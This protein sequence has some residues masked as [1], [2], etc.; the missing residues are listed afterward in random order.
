[1]YV[2]DV[3]A[4]LRRR[5]YIVVT[6]LLLTGG[7]CALAFEYVP[8]SFIARGSMILLPP[9]TV[10]DGENPYL[11]LGGLAP[12]LDVLTRR[13]DADKIR[14]PIEDAFPE[15]EFTVFAD[16]SSSGPIIAIEITAPTAREAFAVTDAVRAVIPV[17]LE[18]MQTELD[19]PTGSRIALSP[20]SV[21]E[22]ATR[23]T[24]TRTQALAV[25][26]GLGLGATVLLTGLVDGLLL[27]RRS[28]RNEIAGA[29]V[30][31]PGP[32]DAEREAA[33][34][35]ELGVDASADQAP[36]LAADRPTEPV[37]RSDQLRMTDPR[38]S[39]RRVRK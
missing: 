21:D 34:L 16:R 27:A 13:V 30:S 7:L 31:S 10:T 11:Y 20:V 24:S 18:Q 1:M 28:R 12:A 32:L 14:L 26:G 29:P 4:G 25:L 35:G 15:A 19:V 2:R 39:L 36:S 22:E 3:V 17:A 8:I 33:D 6:G 9:E 38:G 23:D 5:W 37:K